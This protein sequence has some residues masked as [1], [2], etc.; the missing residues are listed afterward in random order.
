MRNPD[1]VYDRVNDCKGI[2]WDACHKI[3]ILM[4][5]E[6]VE[7]MRDYGYDLLIT[8]NQMSSDEMFEM[9]E[10]WYD[11]SCSLRFIYAVSTN[12]INPNAGFEALSPQFDEYEEVKA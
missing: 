10:N 2:A 1:L 5:S 6:Q 7:L 12:H 8:A 4:D 3:Y 9:I 11:S